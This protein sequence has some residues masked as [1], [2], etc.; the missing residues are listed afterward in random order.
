MKRMILWVTISLLYLS[1]FSQSVNKNNTLLWRISGKDLKSPSYLFGTIHMLCGDDV[2]VSDSLK[3]A[4]KQA[5]KVYLELDMD[6]M[7]ELISVMSK[8]KMRGDT[9]L[10]QLL[11]ANEYEKVK[12]FFTNNKGFIP[13]SMLETYKPML[14]ASTLMQNSVDCSHPMAM[15]QLIMKEAKREGVGIKGLETMAFQ[16]SIFDSIPYGIQAKQLLNYIENYEK[17]DDN[18]E[19]EELTKAYRNQDLKMLEVLTE[20]EDAGV[21]KFSEIMLYRRNEDWAQKL[22]II[23]PNGPVVVAVGAGHLPGE[24]GVINLLRKAGYKVEPVE[25]KMIKNYEKT[26]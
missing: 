5:D 11:T 10:A 8:M 20:K 18:K 2:F 14:A 12:A 19:F 16:M 17:K 21:E 6:N 23:M 3:F 1:C 26:L 13:F 4:I 15:E 22:S 25:N 7:F 9:T 24:R